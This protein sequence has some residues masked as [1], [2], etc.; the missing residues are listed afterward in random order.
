[1]APFYWFVTRFLKFCLWIFYRQKVY[2]IEN[3]HPGKAIIASNHTSFL[4]PPIISAASPEEAHYL[5]REGLFRKAYFRWIIVRLNAHPV[6]DDGT[7]NLHSFKMILSL[8]NENKKVV[9]FPEGIRSYNE[10]LQPLKTGVAMMSLRAEAPIIPAYI[11]GAY[12]AWPRTSK[13]PKPGAR[14]A[15]VFGTPIHPESVSHLDKKHAQEV[16]TNKLAAAILALR[17]W[18][19]EGAKGSPP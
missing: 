19:L 16:L 8:L 15:C 17:E 12:E 9:I 4:D 1:M 11:H 2:G 5:A 18:Y 14:I 13:F 10:E 3:F 6:T 7:R